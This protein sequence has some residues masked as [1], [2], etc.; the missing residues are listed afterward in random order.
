MATEI[1]LLPKSDGRKSN[2]MLLTLILGLL[3][4]LFLAIIIMQYISAKSEIVVLTAMEQQVLSTRDDRNEELANLQGES[5]DSFSA[6]VAF[7]ESVSYP[8]TPLI[9]ELESYLVGNAYLTS[10]SFS[11]S[12]LTI[13]ADFETLSDVATY[14]ENVMRSEYFTDIK[15]SNISKFNLEDS[16]TEENVDEDFMV[17]PRHSVELELSIDEAYL[18]GD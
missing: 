1:N 5:T 7:V 17:I 10:Y 9:G 6:S 3:L 2:P 4:I 8:V 14:V 18:G 13:A 12:S 16:S 15:V 11:E